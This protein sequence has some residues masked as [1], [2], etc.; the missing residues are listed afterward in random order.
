MWVK[1]DTYYTPMG[2]YYFQYGKD[3][4]DV[5]YI[6]EYRWSDYL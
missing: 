1:M 2:T 4:T 6:I 5:N 3:L